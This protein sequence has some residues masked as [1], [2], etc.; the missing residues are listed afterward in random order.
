MR[1][2]LKRLIPFTALLLVLFPFG[3]GKALGQA[4]GASLNGQ[5]TD[6]TGAA[7]PGATITLTNLDTGLALP[8]K[9]SP[10]GAYR[11]APVPPG[12]YELDV[13]AGGFKGYA[14]KGIVIAVDTPS[15]Q[16]VS[17]SIGSAEQTVNVTSNAEMLNTTSGSL[18]TTIDS[19]EITQLPLLNRM[20][21]SLVLLS[22]GMTTGGNSYNQ[23]GFSFP[24]ESSV[25]ANGGDQGSTYFLLDGVPNMDNYLG[26]P[27]PF[28]NSDA[29]KEFRVISNNFDAAYGFA[30]GA[31]V[32]IETKSG[33][34]T[35]HGGVF[36]FLRDSIFNAADY[37]GHQVNPLHQNQFGGYVGG[38][39]LRKKLF[40]FANYQGT[41][42]ATTSMTLSNTL[43][44]TA[45]EAGDFSGLSSDGT[46]ETLCINSSGVYAP[47]AAC[48]FG[49]VNGKP[50]Q[51]LP[52]STLNATALNIAKI[53]LPSGGSQQPNGLIY[54]TSAPFINHLDEETGRLDYDISP[55]QRVFLRSYIRSLIQPSGDVPGNL[56]SMN[57]NWNYDFAINEKYYNETLGYTWTISPTMVNVA[58]VFWNQMDA[59]SG[60]QA[61]TSDKQPF[62]WSKYINVT[63]LP[64]QCFVEGFSI[65]GAYVGYYEPSQEDRTTYGVYDDLTKTL[66]EHTLSFGADVQH[67]TADELTQYPTNPILSF[68]GQYT[69]SALADYLV[70][71]L[72]TMTQGAQAVSY[73]SGWQPGFYAQ[74]QYRLR[75]NL[76]MTAG[77]RWDP[78][79]PPQIL[80]GHGAAF[81]PGQ[82]ST[83]YPNAPA[84]MVF[85]GDHG[86]S[87]GL[88]RATYGYWEPRLGI[89]WQPS[90][91]PHTSFHAGYG[92]FTQ[93]MIYSEYGHVSEVAPFAP[94]YYLQGTSTT[95]LNLDSPWTGFPGG[96]PFAS[97][98]P[99]PTYNPP[100]NTAF[101]TPLDL[102]ATIDPGFKLGVTQSW[103][104]TAEQ[105]L[106]RNTVFRLAYVGSETY[107]APFILDR[108]PGIFANGGG[109]TTYPAFSQILQMRSYGTARYHALQVTLEQ[110]LTH[111]LQFQT[112]FT[113]AK[114]EDLASSANIT[115]GSNQLG[116][117][118]YLPWN[119][120]VSSENIPYRSV[121]NFVYITPYG[122][123]SNPLI[124]EALGGW[125]VSAIITAQSGSPFG[126]G[127]GF[128]ANQSGAAQYQ[129]RADRVQGQSLDVRK[130]GKSNWLNH[131]F[132]VMAFK[133]NALGTFGNS[134][135]NLMQGPPLNYV[136]ATFAKN[137][138]F[139]DRYNL[140]FRWDMFNA[141]N[142]PS[143]ANPNAGNQVNMAGTYVGSTGPGSEGTITST[144]GEPARIGQMS[145]QLTF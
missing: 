4:V 82:Q 27:A 113:W 110:R 139:R 38:P 52:G 70:G 26:L 123:H 53:G 46:S 119:F 122:H 107:H 132:N 64:G 20:P 85:P 18:G 13:Q 121:S 41:R 5:V 111:G 15:T 140:E 127:A 2:S 105:Q 6:S 133:Q 130:G 136:D 94:T 23:T 135:K 34:N 137:L 144:G 108:N 138:K 39:I 1:Q 63:E 76:T 128:G 93:P 37:F 66:S 80:A 31:V 33:T 25:S 114:T 49:I 142:H 48:P 47:S 16:D 42:N 126:V 17:L 112:N 9:S 40:Y 61:L 8:A 21:S 77:L 81:V 120:G 11:I 60:S 29:T 117:P 124:R 91:L 89:A 50:N 78:N 88:M 73:I 30:P 125:E 118:F 75:P 28:P 98:F 67:Q 115:F 43:P 74:D 14:Q 145:L 104:V 59:H 99:S 72:Q 84:G 79:I 96:N 19:V 83:V 95:P 131:Y 101:V 51:L 129:D 35:I 62:C 134:G 58:S 87:G 106:A 90:N 45:M 32:S 86:V 100:S 71:D 24:D 57:N 56:L 68:N 109:R 54:Y 103:N 65:G 22:P 102:S 116:D 97:G 55:S 69:N 143:F 12:S 141:F 92:L 36:D 44:T 3:L 10:N 7:V